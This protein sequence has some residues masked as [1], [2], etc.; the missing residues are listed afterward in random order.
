M[1]TATKLT[2]MLS[3]RGTPAM[4]AAIEAHR[5]ER[6]L[7]KF[8]DAAREVMEIGV[9]A[10]QTQDRAVLE[11]ATNI[12]AAGHDPMEALLRPMEDAA[13]AEQDTQRTTS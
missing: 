7:H 6:K 3:F 2:A 1:Q 5:A 9:A 13:L 8:S 11:A 10:L 4:K 12:R